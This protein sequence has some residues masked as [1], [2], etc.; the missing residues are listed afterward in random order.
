MKLEF[1]CKIFEGYS[2]TQFHVNPSSVRE[3][4]YPMET[5]TDKQMDGKKDRRTHRRRDMKRLIVAFRNFAKGVKMYS[6]N[7]KIFSAVRSMLRESQMFRV[8]NGLCCAWPVLSCTIVSASVSLTYTKRCGKPGG[9]ISVLL[10]L[11]RCTFMP[12]VGQM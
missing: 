11:H 5:N 10:L 4:I 8:S 2:N 6:V 1:S 3:H 7:T 9:G 12:L